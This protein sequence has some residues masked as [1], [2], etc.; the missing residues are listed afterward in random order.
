VWA[1]GFAI[2]AAATMTVGN[3]IALQ[4]TQM[5]RLLAYSSI[6][7]A[8]YM[9]LPFGVVANQPERVQKLAFAGALTYILIYSFMNLGAFA[10]AIAVGS[11][12]P[13]NLISDYEGLAQR[14]PRLAFGMLV[15]LLAL[16]GMVPTAGFWAKFFVFQAAIS[17]KTTWLAALMVINTVIGLYYYLSVGAKMF[18]RE[19]ADRE[20]MRTPLAITVAVV[21]MLLV[22]GALTIYPDLFNHFSPRSTLVAGS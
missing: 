3:V 1:P 4:Q 8:G 18:L 14:E 2:L 7:Q 20:P 16:A 17:A 21:L 12:K 9:L 13:A 11:K 15:F 19:P 6:A 10:V 5:V 22:V